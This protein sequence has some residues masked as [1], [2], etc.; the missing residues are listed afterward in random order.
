VHRSRWRFVADIGA[1]SWENFGAVDSSHNLPAACTHA[2][3]Q[4]EPVETETFVAQRI[5]LIDADHGVA[6]EL[7]FSKPV[8]PAQHFIAHNLLYVLNS[9]SAWQGWC[10]PNFVGWAAS[11]LTSASGATLGR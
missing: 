6:R 10:G 7:R 8:R 3:V 11:A 4:E 1:A 9:G 2:V 5:T